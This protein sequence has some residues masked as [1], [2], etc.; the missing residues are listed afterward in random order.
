LSPK[1][2]LSQNY[3]IS[4]AIADAITEAAQGLAGVLEIG[5]GPG[6]LT[7]RLLGCARVIAIEPDPLAVSVLSETAPGAEILR[8]DALTFDW[9]RAL[10]VLPEPRG[11][12]SNLPYHI[13]GPLLERIEA[14]ATQISRAVLMMQKEVGDRILAP[15][16]DSNHGALSACLQ[17]QFSIRKVIAVP[18]GAFLPAPKVDSIVLAF[19]PRAHVVGPALRALI[20]SAFR[21]P[22]KTLANNLVAAGWQNEAVAVAVRNAGLRPD[23]R[24]HQVPLEAWTVIHESGSTR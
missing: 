12:V 10:E 4:S 20:R 9:H 15:P 18:K 3:L 16:G 17:L 2:V 5:P 8:A 6:A 24:P 11:V 23:I 19:E 7:Q 14:C 13:T 21:M 1:K 22:R